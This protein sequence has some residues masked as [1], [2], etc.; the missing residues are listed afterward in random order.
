MERF[1]WKE[2]VIYQIYWRSF[3]DSNGD[4]VGDLK[5]ILS[6][7]DY[8]EKLGVTVIWL[9]PCYPSPQVDNGYDISDYCGIAPEFGT[10]EE[11]D[12]LLSELH[13]RGM[14]LVMDL[15]VNHTSDQ[16]PWFVQSRS[17]KDNPYRDY[18]I[19]RKGKDGAPPNNWG[20][21]FTPS[22]WEYD[23]ATDE[24]YLHLFAKEQPDLNWENPKVR[25]EVHKIMR[26]WLYKGIDGFRMDVI[27]LVK[28]PE[29]LPDSKLPPSTKEG[30]SFDNELYANNPGLVEFFRE[31]KE[32]VLS[33]YDVMTV[34]ETARVTPE[35]ALQYVGE[36]E[37]LLSMVFHFQIVDL[38]DNFT[39]GK[40]KALQRKWTNALWGKGWA[41]QFLQ[42]HD[43]PRCVSVYGDDGKYREK[44]AKMLATLLHTLPGTPYVY[45]GEEL[46]MCNTPFT[47]ISQYNDINAKFDYD[48]MLAK[49]KSPEQA[50]AVLNRYSRDHSRTPMQWDESANAGFTTGKPWLMVNP[51]YTQINAEKEMQDENSVWNYYRALLALRKEHPVMVYG[52][53]TE[54]ELERED[55]YVYTRTLDDERW[56]VAVNLTGT[57][58]QVT[59]PGAV[60]GT[61][62]RVLGSEAD[63]SLKDGVLTLRPW[64]AVIAAF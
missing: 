62:K 29:G 12:T 56:L 20:S 10:M 61:L 7:L 59:L 55:V 25:R 31:M 36:P 27:N 4:G 52:E 34:G 30:F 23:E 13:A 41:S 58:T 26:F 17:S 14:K 64:E 45:Q 15:V 43:Q 42:N 50:L 54:Y 35:Y 22:A 5:G 40:F 60:N 8:L 16:H 18:Y 9:N 39:W 53:W 44:S 57:P 63:L 47:D 3:Q 21:H 11:F 32:E 1:W 46:G 37:R 24:Y 33:R 49:G 2:A 6:R 38:R 48:E 28:K 19:W 51:N